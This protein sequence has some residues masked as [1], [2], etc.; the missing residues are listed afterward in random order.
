MAIVVSGLAV[1]IYMI[2]SSY[3]RSI[4]AATTIVTNPVMDLEFPTCDGL[5]SMGAMGREVYREFRKS[6]EKFGL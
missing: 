6:S 5:L 3:Q 2:A 4:M 1:V